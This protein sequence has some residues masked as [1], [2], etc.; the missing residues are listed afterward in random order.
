MSIN[1]KK[2]DTLVVGSGQAGIAMSEHLSNLGIEHLVLEKNRI[3]EAWRTR[4]WDSLVAN[5]PCWHDK[6]PN[7]DFPHD[8]DSFVPHGEVAEYFENYAKMIDA[9]I[10]TGV[11]VQNVLK[12]KHK[13]GFTIETSQGTVVADNIV[14]ATG[15]FQ[16]P[17]IPKIAPQ[18]KNLYQIHSDQYKNP[19][20]L[21]EG[22]VLVVGAGSSGVQI[23]SELNSAGKKVYLSVGPHERPPRK[24]RD[25]DNVWWLGV[26][27]TWHETTPPQ[28]PIKG[29]AVS[30]MNGGQSVDFRKMGHEG[31]QLVGMTKAFTDKTVSFNDD[32]VDNIV[33]AEQSYLDNLEE[34]D[35]YIESNGLELPEEPEAKILMDMPDAMKNPIHELDF[36]K[37]NITSIIWASGFGYNYNWLPFDIFQENGAPIHNKGVTSEPGL[38]FVG[39]PYLSGKGSSFIWGVWHDAKRI[40]EYIEIQR[41]YQHYQSSKKTE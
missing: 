16:Q 41:H 14:V 36:D 17:I 24:Y 15:P 4:R 31:I 20:Q 26:L 34:M 5:G 38:Y 11:E 9:P 19:N 10:E 33:S 23:A 12:N 7:M 21:P 6:F 40:A 30:G 3:A 29:F 1:N 25:R 18:N 2:V 39:L 22:A 37:D 28:R 8:P 13:K 35:R 27:G 32:L